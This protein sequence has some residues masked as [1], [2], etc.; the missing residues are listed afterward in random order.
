MLGKP[1]S[2]TAQIDAIDQIVNVSIPDG[3]FTLE[4]YRKAKDSITEGKA[5]GEDGIMPEV[6]KRCN[7]DDIILEFCNNILM[8]GDKPEQFSL[9]NII[10]IP[11][12][13]DLSKTSNYRGISLSSITSKL[14]NRMVLN[15]IRPAIDPHLRLCQNGFR[16]GRTTIAQILCLRRIIEGVKHKQLPAVIVF[17]DFCKAIAW[18]GTYSN[19]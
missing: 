17:I 16:A 8:K 6:I 7:L 12:K 3:P 1:T 18:T 2:V 4:E 9:L 13:G 15:R 11:K 5:A 14:L 10:P 19:F